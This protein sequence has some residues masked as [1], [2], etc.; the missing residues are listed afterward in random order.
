VKIVLGSRG[1][2]LALV[3]TRSVAEQLQKIDPSLEIEITV[4][5]TQGDKLLDLPI[6]Q[7]GDKGL[8]V[9]E[10]E[11]AL[12]EK[13]IDLAVHSVK[14]LPAVIPDDLDL[15]AFP[16]REDP[17]DVLLTK[18][19]LSWEELP[20]GAL[21]GTSALRRQ[22]QL[23]AKR[24]DL[25]IKMLRG[26]VDTR[27][28]KLDE[29]LYFGIVLARAGLHRLGIER[30]VTLPE[31]VILPSPGQG[32]LAI[33]TRKND[34]ELRAIA[35]NLND[36][37]TWHCVT[38]ERSFLLTLEG[39]CQVPLGA[40]AK[41]EKETLILEGFLGTPD[42]KKTLRAQK[43]GSAKEAKGLGKALALEVLDKGHSIL[44]TLKN[45]AGKP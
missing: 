35:K 13:K 43:E 10:L 45:S 4:I 38:A 25:N 34:H 36:E 37:A 39:G 26:N 14:D 11:N 21:L 29:G 42:G 24:P 17:S 1:S 8:F 15:V 32:A 16:L 20:P 9:K 3:Q 5:K 6:W 23:L 27:V 31:S 22:S 7:I 30:G 2:P 40:L 28:R 41:F 44:E 18:D 19:N 12:Q 33:E